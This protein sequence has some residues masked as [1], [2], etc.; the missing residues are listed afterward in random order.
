[1]NQCDDSKEEVTH[2][3]ET[4]RNHLSNVIGEEILAEDWDKCKCCLPEIWDAIGFPNEYRPSYVEVLQRCLYGVVKDGDN[5]HHM[6]NE[7]SQ[8]N[9]E[10]F[11]KK[12]P[13]KSDKLSQKKRVT[14]LAIVIDAVHSD[15]PEGLLKTAMM[16]AQPT[17][18]K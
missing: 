2:T 10:D 15:A 5:L 3:M 17:D 18:V 16:A 6:I 4:V 7:A 8:C 11:K 9:E 1:M 14:K 13:F 12:F